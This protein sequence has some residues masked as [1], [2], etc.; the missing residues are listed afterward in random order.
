MFT[1]KASEPLITVVSPYLFTG[2]E[3]WMAYIF[4]YFYEALGKENKEAIGK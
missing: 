3:I 2:I 4:V 1:T